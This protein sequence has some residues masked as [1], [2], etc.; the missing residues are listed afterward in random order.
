[1]IQAMITVGELFHLILCSEKLSFG[2]LRVLTHGGR[3]LR[4]HILF[5][6]GT[7][8]SPGASVPFV[9]CL[10]RKAHRDLSPECGWVCSCH[11]DKLRVSQ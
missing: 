1:M 10:Q 7:P 11:K 3:R 8:K 9:M 5:I 2:E 4:L 6:S